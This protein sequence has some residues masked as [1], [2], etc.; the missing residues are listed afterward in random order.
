MNEHLEFIIEKPHYTNNWHWVWAVCDPEACW[1]ELAG[2][3]ASSRQEAVDRV[4]E[5][6]RKL[7]VKND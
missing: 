1:G 5:T 3:R 6:F 7:G 2:G 4:R